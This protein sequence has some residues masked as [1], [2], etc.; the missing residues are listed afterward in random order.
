[1]KKPSIDPNEA[2]GDGQKKA[3]EQDDIHKMV[4]TSNLISG[5]IENRL[6]G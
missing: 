3:S 4:I 2:E 1:M 5:G 6:I